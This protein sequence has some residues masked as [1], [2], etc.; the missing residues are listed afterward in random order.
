MLPQGCEG[1]RQGQLVLNVGWERVRAGHD[2][3]CAQLARSTHLNSACK[4]TNVL[5]P[6]SNSVVSMRSVS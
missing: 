5:T 4:H 6:S 2:G 1:C 3:G